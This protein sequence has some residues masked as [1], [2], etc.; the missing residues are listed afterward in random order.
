MQ[1]MLA[2]K[3]NSS[4]KLLTNQSLNNFNEK[5]QAS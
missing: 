5:G 4:P 1:I 3:A 2:Q